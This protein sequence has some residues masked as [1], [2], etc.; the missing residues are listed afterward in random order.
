MKQ[1]RSSVA[2]D[3]HIADEIVP[4][5]RWT[6]L[7][8]EY[9]HTDAFPPTLDGVDLYIDS[10]EAGVD[11]VVADLYVGNIEWKAPVKQEIEAARKRD[12]RIRVRDAAGNPL[13]GATHCQEMISAF[14]DP[15]LFYFTFRSARMTAGSLSCCGIP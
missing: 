9:T 14:P 13:S 3:I 2:S 11:S 1:C 12:V 5:R 7:S 8:G 10:P 4:G 6:R 15:K